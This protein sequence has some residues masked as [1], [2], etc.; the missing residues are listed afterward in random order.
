M[1]IS[2]TTTFSVMAKEY[3]INMLYMIIPLRQARDIILC[4][5]LQLFQNRCEAFFYYLFMLQKSKRKLLLMHTLL[6][7]CIG[8]DFF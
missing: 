6:E 1:H 3:D 8:D 4:L 5:N 7:A 2:S